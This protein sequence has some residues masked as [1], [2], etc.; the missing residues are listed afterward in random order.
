MLSTLSHEDKR[1]LPLDT[2]YVE[3]FSDEIIWDLLFDSGSLR[4]LT[5]EL[6]IDT[7]QEEILPY[8]VWINIEGERYSKPFLSAQPYNYWP[9]ALF[10]YNM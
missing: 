5:R 2:M 9:Y 10:I 6:R 3:K 4:E 1:Y 7:N 8:S